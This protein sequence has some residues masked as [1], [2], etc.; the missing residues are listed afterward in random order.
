MRMIVPATQCGSLIGKGGSKIKEIREVRRALTVA[1]HTVPLFQRTGASI[2]VASEMLPQS[3]ERAVTISGTCEAISDC[4]QEICQILQEVSFRALLG[5]RY[6]FCAL[7]RVRFRHHQ[8][9]PHCRT[10]RNLRTIRY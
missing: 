9:E 3:T 4:M 8:R 7:L 6:P 2:Q 10:G 5:A 1:R